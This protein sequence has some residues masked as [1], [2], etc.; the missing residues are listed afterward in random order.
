M[1][2]KLYQLGDVTPKVFMHGASL[3]IEVWDPALPCYGRQIVFWNQKPR[4]ISEEA[5][6]LT[7]GRKG[8]SLLCEG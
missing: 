6:V 4:R 7:L 8:K 2:R 3:T 1:F 5:G